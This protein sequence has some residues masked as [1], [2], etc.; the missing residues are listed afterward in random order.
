MSEK[1][2]QENTG[3]LSIQPEDPSPRPDLQVPLSFLDCLLQEEQ[4]IQCLNWSTT[5]VFLMMLDYLTDY[6]LELVGS[7]ASNNGRMD[8]SPQNG[9]RE[10]DNCEPNR[11]PLE[12]VS[13]S[14]LDEMPGSRKN[15]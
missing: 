1:K 3:R 10:V 11:R 12:T 8:T 7:E 13:F 14:M 2:S 6:I 5:D 9:E 4:Y 15:G